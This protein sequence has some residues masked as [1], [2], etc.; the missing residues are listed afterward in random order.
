MFD[1]QSIFIYLFLFAIMSIL[2]CE[3][4]RTNTWF[5]II[6]AVLIYSVVFGMRYKVGVDYMGYLNDYKYVAYSIENIN[7]TY[8]EPGFRFIMVTLSNLKAHFSWFFGVVAFI[9]LYLV[10]ASV[11]SFSRIYP[12]L[13]ITFMFSCVWLTYANGLRQQL[14]FCIFAFALSYIVKK[15]WLYYYIAIAISISM[16]NSAGLLLLIYPLLQYKKEW[17]VNVKLQ[18]I[19]L[20]IAFIIGNLSFLQNYL[21]LLESY[22]S[23]FGYERYFLDTHEEAIYKPLERKGIGYY[24][25]LLLNILLVWN[26]ANFKK[27]FNCKYLYYIYNLYF[28]GLLT[29]FAFITTLIIQRINYYFYGFV[30]I[31]GAFALLYA[32]D[33]NKRLYWFFLMLYL[34]I[35][36]ATLYRCESNTSL[37]RFYWQYNIL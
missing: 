22:V 13:L 25:I 31:V 27:Y 16:H 20:L 29:R 30:Y 18:L 19:L 28:I 34:L 23:V 6:I 7:D 3:A 10:F 36:I 37:F 14:A 4:R 8:Y 17:F 11:K 33:T 9:Q 12:F 21:G 15:Q 5:P 32:K 1:F 26:S 35:F 2:A 24:V